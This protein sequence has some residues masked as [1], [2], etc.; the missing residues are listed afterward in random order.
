MMRRSLNILIV[1]GL[2]CAPMHSSAD[3][4]YLIANVPPNSEFSQEYAMSIMRGENKNWDSGADARV[5]L[6]SRESQHYDHIANSLIGG[7]GKAMERRWFALVFSG[8]VNAPKY[9][10]D[11]SAVMDFI[12]STQGAI[13]IV[14]SEYDEV[15]GLIVLKIQ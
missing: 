7:S 11:D 8:K 14:A 15:E 10:E 2:L 1:L 12:A 13:G 3:A 9:L 6:P 4:L 5:A